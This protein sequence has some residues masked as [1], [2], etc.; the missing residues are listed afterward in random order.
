M[1]QD[2]L[3]E[4]EH[5]FNEQMWLEWQNTKTKGLDAAL[6]FIN[7]NSW[8]SD[9]FFRSYPVNTEI[10]ND[11]LIGKIKTR[12][13]IRDRRSITKEK[14]THTLITYGV[15]DLELDTYYDIVDCIFMNEEI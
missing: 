2:L 10:V 13:Q 12:Q 9:N 7:N 4:A 11:L 3:E 14:L 15:E 1:A 8:A 5:N 6:S